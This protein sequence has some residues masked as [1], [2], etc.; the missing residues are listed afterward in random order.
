[1][2]IYAN[3]LRTEA[4]QGREPKT[5]KEIFLRLLEHF[6][7]GNHFCLS[8]LKGKKRVV[9][10]LFPI[11]KDKHDPYHKLPGRFEV[12]FIQLARQTRAQYQS[13]GCELRCYLSYEPKFREALEIRDSNE[14]VWSTLSGHGE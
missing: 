2:S 5:E 14:E 11:I 9:W 1:M 4:S 10:S 7:L 6:N 12:M 13:Q 8:V 3:W